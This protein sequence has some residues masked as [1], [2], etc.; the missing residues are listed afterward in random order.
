MLKFHV[1]MCFVCGKFN[2][3]VMDSQDMCRHYKAKEELLEPSRPKLAEG[4]KKQLKKLLSQ[5]NQ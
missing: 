3:Q 2:R 1:A 4:Q 5:Q